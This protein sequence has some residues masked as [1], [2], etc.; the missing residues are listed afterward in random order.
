[1]IKAKVPHVVCILLLLLGTR[2]ALAES[3][4][5]RAGTILTISTD[6]IEGG[7]VL[8]VDGKI[9]AVGN[10]VVV[11]ANARIINARD[12]VVLP[13]LMDAQSSLYLMAGQSDGPG[14][15][16]LDITDGLD[17]FIERTEEVLAQGVTAV[18][19]TPSGAGVIS[20]KGAVV[21]LNGAKTSEGLI[22]KSDVAVKATIGGSSDQQSASLTRL[23]D[24]ANLRETFIATQAYIQGQRQY[25]QQLAKYEKQQAQKKDAKTSEQKPSPGEKAE[26]LKRPAK[27]LP[28]PT[29]EVL[30]R[31]LNKQIPLQI[32]AHRTTDILN[33]LRLAEE[34]DFSLILDGCTEGHTIVAEIARGR[35]PV[36]VG[37]ISTSFADAPQLKYRHHSPENAGVLAAR[38][39]QTAI[40]M[41][42]RDGLSSKFIALAAATA[43]ANGMDRNAALRA[44]TLTPAEIFGVADRI[45]SLD[46]G[47]DA[48]IVIMTGHPFETASKVEQVL[49]QGKTVYERK[50]TP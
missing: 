30:K 43:V 19:V 4:A 9:Q 33:A 20:G 5:I 15:P 1:M 42:G 49:I 6:P 23:D 13:G 16:E 50:S 3:I 25:E 40:G 7:T 14:A 44:I 45:G 31:I 11:S 12:K 34:F 18:Y 39:I 36:V 10:N 47:K 38:G 22:L 8:I 26:E 21:R 35:V 28:N 41:V 27:P 46:V 29:Y 17:P 24:Y 2:S 48:D 32:E 37:P